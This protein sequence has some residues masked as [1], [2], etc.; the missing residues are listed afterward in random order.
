MIRPNG[1]G[2]K[3]KKKR[4]IESVAEWIGARG[5]NIDSVADSLFGGTPTFRRGKVHA[6]KEDF[7]SDVQ[8]A[9]KKTMGERLR[10]WGYE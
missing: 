6:W 8:S 3:K 1:G 2:N 10:L 7:T 9:F 5:I 4:V